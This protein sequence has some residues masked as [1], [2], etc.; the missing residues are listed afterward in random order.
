M[1]ETGGGCGSYTGSRCGLCGPPHDFSLTEE[2]GRLMG[3]RLKLTAPTSP[4]PPS[5]QTTPSLPS[6]R[7]L[8]VQVCGRDV[9][10]N[11]N[12]RRRR[13]E[14]RREGGRIE[15]GREVGEWWGGSGRGDER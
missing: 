11:L 3:V 14:G 4:P 7:G 8:Q 15:A 1:K 6:H 13:T 9:P 5:L 10:A 2:D 12:V